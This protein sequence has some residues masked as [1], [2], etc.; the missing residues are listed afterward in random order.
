MQN[1]WNNKADFGVAMRAA[2]FD[3]ARLMRQSVP[4]G[5][6]A[7][8]YARAAAR[9]MDL[10]DET[11]AANVDQKVIYDGVYGLAFSE[12]NG[13]F[14]ERQID[15]AWLEYAGMGTKANAV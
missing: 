11:P 5:T 1:R 7:M 12:P 3:A 10:V 4:P 13:A 6:N 9:Q 8:A 2:A 14:I 15:I